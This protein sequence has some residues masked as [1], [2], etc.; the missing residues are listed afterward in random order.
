MTDMLAK[1]LAGLKQEFSRTYSGKSHV[2]EAIVRP[3]SDMF[4]IDASHL[5]M[6]HRFAAGNP[7]YTNSFE[8]EIGSVSCVVYEGDANRYWL[9]SIGHGSSR[10]P[11]S[12]TWMMS[13]Y[14]A[15][16]AGK[17]LGYAEAVDIGSGDGRIAFCAGV[18]GMK[19]HSIELDG[20]LAGLQ[21]DMTSVLDFDP[22]CADAARFD[23]S[24]LGLSRPL[25]FVG[26]LAQMGGASL[27]RGVMERVAADPPLLRNSGW[28]F[29]GT[30]SPKYAPDPRGEAGWGTLIAEA[31][32]RVVRRISLPAAW[33]LGEEKDVSYVFAEMPQNRNLH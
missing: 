29:A 33:T 16:L 23:Y 2:R 18:L 27:A 8:Q 25:F 10:A 6:L 11:F 31:G 4:P 1:N 17:S 21:R 19:P 7:I 12:P 14:V 9:S 22:H 3:G 30:L 28:V 20:M 15:A 5:E 26:G 13:G 32:L 24:S